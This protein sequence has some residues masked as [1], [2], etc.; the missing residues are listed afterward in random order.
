MK[1][2]SFNFAKNSSTTDNEITLTE[3]PDS[4]CVS[5]S[6]SVPITNST[7]KQPSTKV[8]SAVGPSL[9][10]KE[11]EKN[12]KIMKLAENVFLLK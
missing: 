2:A 5:A 8:A 10:Q 4:S 11:K 3:S 6:V 1:Q 7:V 12:N 9:E